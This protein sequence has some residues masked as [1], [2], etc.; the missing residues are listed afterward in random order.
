LAAYSAPRYRQLVI[1]AAHFVSG[2]E[3][4]APM[5]S[6]PVFVAALG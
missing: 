5:L 4:V 6:V 1:L 3:A 2:G